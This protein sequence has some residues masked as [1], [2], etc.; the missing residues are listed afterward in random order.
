MFRWQTDIA[1]AREQAFPDMRKTGLFGLPAGVVYSS[2]MAHSSIDKAAIVKYA[3]LGLATVADSLVPASNPWHYTIS[4]A[5]RFPFD[6][7][8]ARRLLNN[9][10]WNYTATGNLAT[11]TTTP[12]YRSLAADPGRTSGLSFRFYT[13][14]SHTEFA[15]AAANITTWLRQA[16]IQTVDHAGS[17]A[18]G[19]EVR[20]LDT[21]NDVW[22]SSDFDMWLWD[23]VFSPISDPST[24][25]LSVQTTESIPDTSDSWYSNATYDDLYNQSLV[26]V[27]PAARRVLTDEMQRMLYV[28]AHY[29]LPYY[30]DDLYATTTTKG[31]GYG[32]QDWGDWLQQPGL[33]PDS[34][35]P[36]LWFRLSP[37]DNLPPTISSFVK[38]SSRRV[39]PLDFQATQ[40]LTSLFALPI[41]VN[42]SA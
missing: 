20:S 12:L 3:Y 23:W 16:G 5:D 14:N 6:P 37:P 10:G 36:S 35:N 18:P 24:D 32:W 34:D 30:A 13:P 31:Y 1:A 22:K 42:L 39:T 2:E 8:G 38:V 9:A 4:A 26:T 17:S 11:A 7:A 19:Y 28:N 29:I 25:V 33:V 15:V 21:M 40:T 27:D 41:H